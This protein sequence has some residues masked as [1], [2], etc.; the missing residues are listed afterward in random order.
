VHKENPHLLQLV[1]QHYKTRGNCL[2]DIKVMVVCS[3]T[4]SFDQFARRHSGSLKLGH[5]TSR[6]GFSRLRG[7]KISFWTSGAPEP[8]LATWSGWTPTEGM[9]AREGKAAQEA[10]AGGEGAGSTNHGSAS[11]GSTGHER[12]GSLNVIL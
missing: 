1:N 9:A 2:A 6:P 10:A 12:E 11:R 8:Y 3:R 5:R 4:P 7:E